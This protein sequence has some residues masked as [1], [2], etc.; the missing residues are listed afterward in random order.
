MESLDGVPVGILLLDPCGKPLVVN[1]AASEMLAARDGLTL[2]PEGLTAA[3]REETSA[4]RGLI[5][6]AA[7]AG[8]AGSPAGRV[9]AL[10]RP[11]LRR[12]FCVLVRPLNA[13]APAP[14]GSHPAVAVFLTDPDRRTKAD[15]GVLQDLYGF[16]P[17]ESRV[18]AQLMQGEG[19]EEAA[20][21]LDVS[22]NTARTHMRH[23]LEKTDTHS[24]RELLRL[25]LC[26]SCCSRS[27]RT[28]RNNHHS[29]LPLSAREKHSLS[30]GFPPVVS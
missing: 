6:Q 22:L 1:R 8:A 5:T 13:A 3:T 30:G 28:P 10:S 4:L 7:E 2:G 20:K 23:L 27:S 14:G 24:H 12:A 29:P 17:A 15:G 21:D 9:L 26:S 19:V 18:A 25:L 16:T 11:S